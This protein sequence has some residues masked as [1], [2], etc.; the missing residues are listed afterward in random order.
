[1]LSDHTPLPTAE[2]KNEWSYTSIPLYN[3]NLHFMS[4]WRSLIVTVVII[5]TR[6]IIVKVKKFALSTL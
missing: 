6:V 5:I 2:V 1:M 4:V 3:M